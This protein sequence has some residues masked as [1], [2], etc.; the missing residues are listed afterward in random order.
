VWGGDINAHTGSNSDVTPT[1]TAGRLFLRT[2]DEAGIL[3]V[4][5]IAGVCTC[6]PTRVQVKA[7]TIESTTID[8]VV[9]SPSIA[10]HLGSLKI[11]DDAMDSDNK[12]LVLRLRG[13]SVPP[14][15]KEPVREVLRIDN[16]PDAT[17]DSSWVKACRARLAEWMDDAHKIAQALDVVGADNAHIG[18]LLEWSFQHAL[19]EVSPEQLGARVVKPH[20][21][22]TLS[23]HPSLLVQQRLVCEDIMKKFMGNRNCSKSDRVGARCHFLAASKAV[24]QASARRRELE[25]LKL[26]RD[27]E[28][29]QRDWKVFWSR[30]KKMKNS[31]RIT[32]SPPP[33]AT[34]CK[35]KTVTDPIEVLRAW[36]DFSRLIASKELTGTDVRR[37]RHL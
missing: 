12:P 5:S 7:G 10:P 16:I 31:I 34:D 25:E 30:F 35:G 8:Y 22:P 3:L 1:D 29:A 17:E 4:N 27:V 14:P 32:K 23:E 37:R 20:R 18:D 2:L 6:G 36:R 13:L 33:V 24:R 19:D 15:R 11:M 26:F 28:S 21:S 9:C